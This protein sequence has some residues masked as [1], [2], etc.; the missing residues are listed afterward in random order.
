MCATP[1]NDDI[2]R[3]HWYDYSWERLEPL[4]GDGA[5]DE[6]N[7]DELDYHRN[8]WHHETRSPSSYVI[9]SMSAH[10]AQQTHRY[11]KHSQDPKEQPKNHHETLQREI[12]HMK[13]YWDF[14]ISGNELNIRQESAEAHTNY[15]DLQDLMDRNRTTHNVLRDLQERDHEP[16]P[17]SIWEPTPSRQVNMARVSRRVYTNTGA[18]RSSRNNGNRPRRSGRNKR[19][20]DR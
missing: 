13:Q 2:R 20:T 8:R 17:P 11:I 14:F 12:Q 6:T 1:A 9:P 3:V 4:N 18:R 10:E 5:T 7:E 19:Q 16:P 15:D